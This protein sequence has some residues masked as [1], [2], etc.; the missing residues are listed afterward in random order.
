MQ[1]LGMTL[2]ILGSQR[3]ARRMRDNGFR[4]QPE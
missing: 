1:K 4:L 2:P 3:A